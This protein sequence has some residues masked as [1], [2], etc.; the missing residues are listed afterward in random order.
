MKKTLL[1]LLF[2][3]A[4]LSSCSSDDATAP[5]VPQNL[6]IQDFIWKAMNH[7]YFWQEDVPALADTQDD[8]IDEYTSYLEQFSGPE[9]LFN[10]LVFSAD[11]FSWFIDDVEAQLNSFNGISE[12]YGIGLPSNLVRV[13][14]N[15]NI[16]IFVAYVEPGS[17]AAMAGIERGDLI[18]K[19]NG[20]VLNENNTSLV[21]KIF[22]DLSLSL[23]VA[24]VENGILTP[25]GDDRNLT[26]VTLSINPVHFSSIIEEAGKKIG[27]LVYNRFTSTYHEE[28]NNVFGNF[29]NQGI[30]ELILDMRYNPG[31]SVLTSAYLSSMI[32]GTKS[33]GQLFASL[34]YNAKRNPENESQYFFRDDAAI[35][36]KQTGNFTN[37]FVDI[38]RLSNLSR[39]YVLTTRRTASASEMIINGLNPSMDVVIVGTTTVGKNEG[40]FTVVDAP[41]DSNSQIFTD[42]GNRNSNHTVGLQ[43]IVFQIFNGI[44][45]SDYSDGFPPDIAIDELN[46]SENILPFGDTNEALLRAA[47]DDIG[48]ATKS[49]QRPLTK[50]GILDAIQPPKFTDEM[51]ILPDEHK[52]DR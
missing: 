20:E 34:T 44:G 39:V 25:K 23:G 7:W 26:A 52:I 33:D 31:G 1:A 45:Q 4:L 47:L 28:L 6:E 46:F 42:T 22:T 30:D 40:S 50:I 24:T 27:Y 21:N 10:S 35:F 51:Y 43:P 5:E 11:D 15:D 2:I 9:S 8:N 12:S 29:V 16:V 19:V 38:N 36:D 37:T 17:P 14:E 18:Y 32:E 3:G 48:T 49:V 13:T 41:A